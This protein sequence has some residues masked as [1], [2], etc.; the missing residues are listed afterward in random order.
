MDLR[1]SISS[2]TDVALSIAKHLFSKEANGNNLVFSPL[3]VH[4]VLSIVAA[5]SK[6]PTRNQLLSFLRSKSTD[7]LNSFASQLV[8]VVLSDGS[9]AGGPRLSFADGVWV[10]QSLSLKPSFKQ[11]VNND[12]K[13]AL[14]SVD[15]QTKVKSPSFSLQ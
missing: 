12:Y 8:A 13:A 5:G 4:V 7:H 11:L 9:P 1:E 14:A 3:S 2:Q 10:D 6:G 15:F